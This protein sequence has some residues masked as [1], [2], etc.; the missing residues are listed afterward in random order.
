MTAVWLR[1][2]NPALYPVELG[3]GE[4]L[5]DDQVDQHR[6]P[7]SRSS[8][9]AATGTGGARPLMSVLPCAVP[10]RPAGRANRRHL[11]GGGVLAC[12]E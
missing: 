3:I 6:K 2:E 7:S 8:V 9:P 10:V 4:D 5:D 12:P 11:P 1:M